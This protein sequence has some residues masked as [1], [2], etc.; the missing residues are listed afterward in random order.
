MATLPVDLCCQHLPLRIT[1]AME[2]IQQDLAQLHTEVSG[3]DEI[4]S[5]Q[6]DKKSQDL[7][8]RCKPWLERINT[9]LR[10]DKRQKSQ[11]AL[12]LVVL[13]SL[14]VAM[15]QWLHCRGHCCCS[16]RPRNF[17]CVRRLPR[18]E[19]RCEERLLMVFGTFCF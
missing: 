16:E 4:L 17:S 9:R 1:T 8:Q 6:V 5:E 18:K 2:A 3:S 15:I 13:V 14:R 12:P 11:D 19:R 10:E 7:G